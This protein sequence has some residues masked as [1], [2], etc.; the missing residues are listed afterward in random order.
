[1]AVFNEGR[2]KSRHWWNLHRFQTRQWTMFFVFW[3]GLR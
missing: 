3:R 1:M 2:E